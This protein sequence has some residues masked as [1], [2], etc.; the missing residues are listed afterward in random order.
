MSGTDIR[1]SSDLNAEHSLRTILEEVG[2]TSDDESIPVSGSQRTLQVALAALRDGRVSEIVERFADRF[3][4]NDHALRLEFTEKRRLTEFF[5]KSRELFPDST[6]EIVSLFVS[7][8]HAMAEW[9][10]TATESVPLGSIS[11]RVPISLQGSTI[12]CVEN[13]RIVRWADYYDQSSSLPIHLAAYRRCTSD[14]ATG[15]V[16]GV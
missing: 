12:I 6:R 8:D 4:F 5:E 15:G 10:L 13:E 2:L 14:L 9:R 3:T 1:S 7:G 11:H 16:V